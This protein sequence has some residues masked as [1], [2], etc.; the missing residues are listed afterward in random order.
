MLKKKGFGNIVFAITLG[1]AALAL[2]V[3]VI[4]ILLKHSDIY[5]LPW[6][7]FDV[8]HLYYLGYLV[9]AFLLLLSAVAAFIGRFSHQESISLLSSLL[10]AIALILLFGLYEVWLIAVYY[11]GK[12]PG[13]S[14]SQLLLETG[15]FPLLGFLVDLV[16]LPLAYKKRGSA[17]SFWLALVGFG[18]AVVGFI[19]FFFGYPV[20]QRPLPIDNSTFYPAYVLALGLIA[21]IFLTASFL[22]LALGAYSPVPSEIDEDGDEA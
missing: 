18:L 12:F 14:T 8:D 13:D 22:F 7:A 21:G 1:L 4:A 9:A 15:L 5:R 3:A 16:A 10:A 17:V 20:A 6:G 11:Q 19:C 2:I